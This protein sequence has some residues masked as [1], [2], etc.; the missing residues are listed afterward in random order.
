MKDTTHPNHVPKHGLDHEA[1]QAMFAR[2]DRQMTADADEQRRREHL[3]RKSIT[4]NHPNYFP[5]SFLEGCSEG[6][7][8]GGMLVWLS[9][10]LACAIR[11]RAIPRMS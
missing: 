11:L 8:Y 3:R 4:L 10:R 7:S 2:S 9:P 6:C 1:M 5:A